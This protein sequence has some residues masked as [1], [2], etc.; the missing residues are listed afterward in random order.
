MGKSRNRNWSKNPTDVNF[1]I[2]RKQARFIETVKYFQQSLG[3]LADSMTD[4]EREN[5]TKVF[6]RF[7]AEKL[8]FLTDEDEKWVLDYLSS[9]KRMIP[10]QMIEDFDSLQIV[11]EDGFFKYEDFYSSL[12]EKN[13]ILEEYES[14]KKF[15]TVLRLKTL[16]DLNR[17]YNFQDTAILCEIFELRNSLLQKLFKFNAR[18]CN[19]ASNFSGCVQRFKSKCCIALPT[20]AEVIRVFEKTLIGGYSCVNTRMAFDTDFFLKDIKNEKFLYKTADGQLKRFSSKIIEMDE[21]NQYGQTM[22][23]PLPYGCIKKTKKVLS[24]EELSELLK[25]VTLENKIGHLFTVGIEFSDI[26]SKTLLFN[27]IYPPI[28]EKKKKLSPHKR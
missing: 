5:V 14:V 12:K 18:K 19:S 16:G 13:I 6:R 23:K 15:F 26:N 25:A 27:E 21:N 2:I 9:G 17:I 22:T 20:D 4:V 10:Y 24:L 28:F 3:S 7:L 11:P 1:V 8:M